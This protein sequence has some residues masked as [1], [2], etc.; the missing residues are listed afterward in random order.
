[1]YETGIED[2]S[3][4]GQSQIVTRSADAD[5]IREN[6]NL[7][8]EE[9][10][11]CQPRCETFDGGYSNQERLNELEACGWRCSSDHRQDSPREYRR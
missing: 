4:N 5:E 11:F 3:S 6:G 10:A 9:E 1:M 8:Q 2:Q 7:G